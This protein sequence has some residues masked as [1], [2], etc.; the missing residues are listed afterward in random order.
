MVAHVSSGVKDNRAVYECQFMVGGPGKERT[1]SSPDMCPS[2]CIRQSQIHVGQQLSL[3]ETRAGQ[4]TFNM[5]NIS[6]SCCIR[7]A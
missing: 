2:P 1:L 5:I 4:V 7:H 3:R 6:V